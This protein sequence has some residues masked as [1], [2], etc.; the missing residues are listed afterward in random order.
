MADHPSVERAEAVLSTARSE[1]VRAL[2]RYWLAIHPRTGLPGRRD[3]DPAMIPRILPHLVLTDVEGPPHRF[4]ARL[5]G[6]AV[7]EAIGADFTG[8]YLDDALPGFGGTGG[9]ADRILVVE[10][11]LPSHRYGAATLPFRLDFAPLE[12]VYL[13]L[14]SDGRRVDMILA[15]MAYMVA[16]CPL[17]AGPGAG[18][19]RGRSSP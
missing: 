18:R 11:G 15:A 8:E 4:R 13:P 2:V 9:T 14:A 6:T 10:T 3:I 17:S 1:I 5:V 7:V 16:L 12:R 19:D